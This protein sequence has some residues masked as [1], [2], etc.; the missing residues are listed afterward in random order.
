VL[1]D[2]IHKLLVASFFYYYFLDF[3]VKKCT[4]DLLGN[5]P[6]FSQILNI[7]WNSVIFKFL[8]ILF[9]SLWFWVFCDIDISWVFEPSSFC[10]ISKCSM[11]K[12]LSSLLFL[13]IVYFL[14]C[15][16]FSILTISTMS[17]TWSDDNL[18]SG[19]IV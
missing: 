1:L 18:Y 16:Y 2:P 8:L 9:V 10:I 15:I 4:F 5:I 11:M 3:N 6:E 13:M 19:W 17:S 14:V 7:S 12:F